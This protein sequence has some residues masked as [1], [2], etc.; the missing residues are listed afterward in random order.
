MSLDLNV[1]MEGVM[2]Q[3]GNVRFNNVFYWE[4]FFIAS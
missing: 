3:D 1:Q 4:L 2:D